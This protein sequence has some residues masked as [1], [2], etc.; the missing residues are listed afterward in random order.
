VNE[1][2]GDIYVVDK[3]EVGA[4][5]G[6]VVRFD[7]AGAFQSEFNGS[8][9]LAGEGEEAGAGGQA[10]E[11]KT[12]RFEAPNAIAVDNSCALRKLK[13]PGLTLAACEAADPSNGDVYVVD[14]GEEHE[15]EHR[16]VDKY[17]ATGK[18][19]GQITSAGASPGENPLQSE[20]LEGVAVDPAGTVWVYRERPGIAGF[21]K[22]LATE[23]LEEVRPS[24][25]GGFA[26]TGLAVDS[27]GNFYGALHAHSSPQ[28]TKWNPSGE[29]INQSLDGEGSTGLAAEQISDAAFV[30]NGTSVGAFSPGGVQLER[31]GQGH[32]QEGAG[33]GV[34]AASGFLYVADPALGPVVVFA[35]AAA[36]APK[37]EA[38][39]FSG[40]GDDRASL[41]AEINPRS[42]TNE[43]PSEYHFQYGR[44]TS[45]TSCSE[46]GYEA[47]VPVPDGQISAD[48]EV[49]SVTA[50]LE[51]LQ[52][53][54]TYH[55][56][57][58]A[59]NAHGEGQAGKETIFTTEGEGG[60]LTLPDDRGW[61]LVSPP[62]K[63]GALIAP[64]SES[65]V[66]QAAA[67][68]GGITY[69]ANAP[70]EAEPQGNASRVQ[71]LSRRGSASWSSRDIAIPHE[72]AT[73]APVGEGP[74]FKSFDAELNLSAVQPF[75]Q[76]NAGL[77]AEASEST[78]YLHSL[79]DSCG[80]LCF[81]PLVSGKAP[82]A[83]VPEGTVFGEEELCEPR[84]GHQEANVECGPQFVGASEDLSHVVLS[85]N[86]ALTPGGV[87]GELYEWAG[88]ALTPV[89]V[90]A[91][92]GGAQ[93]AGALGLESQAARGAISNDGT[94]IAWSANENLYER[95]SARGETV[96]L[97]EARAPLGEGAQEVEE[98]KERSGGGHFQLA[99]A[100]GSRVLFTDEQPL[101]ADSGAEKGKP[102]LYECVISVKAGKLACELSDLT[103]AQGGESADVLGG[104]LGASE[105]ATTV[106]FVAKG[107]LG[108][109]PNA[110]G[111]KAVAGQANLYVHRDGETQFIAT[112]SGEDAHDWS[113]LL[114]SQ[115]TRVSAS[116]RF[117]ELMSQ[118]EFGGYDNRD[119]DRDRDSGKA[120]A[121]VYLYD[122][123]S[124]RLAC[125]SC[126]PSGQRPVGVEYHKLEP[127][128]G[129][130]V[131][132]G[133]ET[134]QD[135]GLVAGNVPGWT[136]IRSANPLESRYQPR[137]L[138]DSGRLFFNS[139]DALVP[140]DSNGTQDVYEYEP[141][142]VGGA[143]GC[144]KASSTY[145]ARSGGCVSLISSG[146]SA[147]ESAFL[148]ASES[149][150]DVYFLTS[151]KLS[152]LDVDSAR[153][154]Y[155]AHVCTSEP[156]IVFAGPQPPPCST[157]ASCKASPT[158]QPTIFGTPASA[159]FEGAGNP[160]PAP[161][162]APAAKVKTAA[163]IRAERLAKA[164]KACKGKKNKHKRQACEKQAR[165]K[166]GPQKSSSKKKQGK[167]K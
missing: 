17:S 154:V 86:A 105:D 99:S 133:R 119:R 43:A 80:A 30:D 75:G 37:V 52:P 8:G 36:G 130:L 131:G 143:S 78:A 147:Q 32:L 63:R 39:S 46:S 127:G 27:K 95:D 132:G 26:A 92:A 153:D 59:K 77:S 14:A 166:Y 103:A 159:T 51:G 138:S 49:H 31:L 134:W 47:S 68:G 144:S 23:F 122:A 67:S 149:G 118:E 11:I 19:L 160:D 48:F 139:I 41:D 96:Q 129:G 152:P 151:A 9:L 28:V 165:K 164:L 93:V 61:E 71:V 121:E 113:E 25:L 76:F 101:T 13:E 89:S 16:V 112:L 135:T 82:F 97:D 57:A 148:D 123:E 120:A 155:D 108:E 1:A 66:V 50:E 142:G 91:G 74:E 34:N 114:R 38:E 104:V 7:A 161:A 125:A 70:S 124:G 128:S 73:G 88:G 62:D 5:H 145:G 79:S 163:Q 4:A 117:L 24:A 44:C 42:E 81:R 106:Y 115:P 10:G 40:V 141:P 72:S 22:G 15:G 140:Q 158:P 162:P 83:N 126:E 20:A 64:I 2:D 150:D 156:C 94:R 109:A 58:I 87:P 3:G 111:K 102:D 12:G 45:A 53:S 69:L 60:Q 100:D 116:G 21:A 146:S 90:L 167:K 98:R 54:T 55:F 85:A 6:R 136:Q 56:R 18:Y 84:P 35:P 157:E 107:V 137:Y 65:G 29:I 33:I 110:E